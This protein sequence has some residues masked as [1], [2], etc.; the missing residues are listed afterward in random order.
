MHP[1]PTQHEVFANPDH[2]NR[3]HFP[4][5][6]VVQADMAGGERRIVA[7]L[8]RRIGP[9]AA[10]RSQGIPLVACAG[11]DLMLVLPLIGTV[12]ASR[13][14]PAV[15]SIAAFRDEITRAL[16]WLLFGI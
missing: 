1:T 14:K 15:G 5:V 6:A 10:L 12:A 13:L 2:R 11:A 4:Y 3:G 8:A 9:Y 16:D 7:P